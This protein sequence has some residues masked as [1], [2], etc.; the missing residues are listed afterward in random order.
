MPYTVSNRLEKEKD[1][2]MEHEIVIKG[3]AFTHEHPM[4]CI[5]IVEETERAILSKM[6]ELMIEAPDMIEWRIDYFEQQL[7]LD[8]V[9][10]VLHKLKEMAGDTIL[11]ATIRTH[12]QGGKYQGTEQEYETA[13]I[14]LSSAKEA[15]IL[16]VEFF[17]VEN[18]EELFQ[19]LHGFG[20]VLIASHHDFNETPELDVMRMLLNDM[21]KYGDIVKLAVM[22]KN[23]SDVL[24]LLKVT[25]DYCRAYEGSPIITMSMGKLGMVTRI[26]GEVFGSCVTFGATGRVSAPGQ[27]ERKEL[28]SVLDFMHKH[29]N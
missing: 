17:S 15:D 28:R 16:D 8:Q 23:T 9:I 20:S 2:N 24:N 6:E 5:P 3:K 4:I 18:P 1:R 21:T 29:Y 25:N 11:L 26:C 12:M 7:D 14:A 22:P 10:G 19:I 13:L 27:I